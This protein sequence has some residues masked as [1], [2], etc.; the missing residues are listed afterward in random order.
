MPLRMAGKIPRR[1]TRYFK[2]TIKPLLDGP[3]AQFVG[4][5]NEKQKNDFLERASAL[6][7]QST[8]RS[9]AR[10]QLMKDNGELRGQYSLRQVMGNGKRRFG[11]VQRAGS[12]FQAVRLR[13][14]PRR[15]G[16]SRKQPSMRLVT[17]SV[18]VLCTPRVV[19]QWCEA[20]ISTPTP[21]GL[22]TLSMV[23]AI[24]AVSF[25]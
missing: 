12:L 9:P 23:L 6:S 3:A 21:R 5:V 1:E 10:K 18:S 13:N 11:A 20:R 16:S 15:S 24:W 17:R 7:F 25:S 8:G 4:E 2:H 22:S 19:M 14:S